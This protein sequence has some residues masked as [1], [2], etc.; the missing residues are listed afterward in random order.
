MEAP[1]NVS[2]Y[3]YIVLTLALIFW[4]GYVL[5][6]DPKNRINRSFAFLAASMAIWS[7]GFAG[8]NYTTDPQLALA[9]RRFSALGW[10]S[11]YV[12]A[13][14]FAI[15]LT[16]KEPGTKENR[17]LYLLYLP[18]AINI[19]IFALSSRGARIQYNLTR[20]D[21]GWTNQAVHNGWDFFFYISVITYA[22]VGFILLWRWKRKIRER[23]K[24][25]QANI[26]VWSFLFALVISVITD[27]ILS[28]L[29]LE[30]I[31]QLG[32]IFMAIPI[33][34]MY[35]ASR[36]YDLI[37]YKAAATSPSI[38]TGKE[39]DRVF[40]NLSLTFIGAGIFIFF[41]VYYGKSHQP[42]VYEQAFFKAITPLLTGL[43]IYFYRGLKISR[44]NPI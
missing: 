24:V 37:H 41:M 28:G 5:K 17:V 27:I 33:W 29:G 39:Q 8:S 16:H 44:L 23:N 22:L 12:F 18:A 2:S 19:Y 34:A 3:V 42:Q 26:I 40:K 31:P 25:I 36:Y 20:T 1:L 35:Y 43:V 10:A 4:G 15:F 38:M 7:L 11:V 14:H 30:N 32:P 6:L 21:Y 9:W 13:L